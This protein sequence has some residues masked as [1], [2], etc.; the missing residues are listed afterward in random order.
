MT[1]SITRSLAA[2]AI[3]KLAATWPLSIFRADLQKLKMP[4]LIVAGRFDRIS[5]PRYAIEYKKYAPQARFVIMEESGHSVRRASRR[6][7]CAAT[8]VSEPVIALLS[9]R[10]TVIPRKTF[11]PN[12][13]LA[14]S[15]DV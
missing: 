10:L 2:T 12:R 11:A 8:C 13:V 15:E 9:D 14:L 3:S 5:M 4:I 1:K 6:D 7:L